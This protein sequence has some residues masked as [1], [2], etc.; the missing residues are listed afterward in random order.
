[1]ILFQWMSD[2]TLE[3]ILMTNNRRVVGQGWNQKR[4]LGVFQR[5]ATRLKRYRIRVISQEPSSW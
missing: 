3:S 4:S 2:R 5:R 1:M